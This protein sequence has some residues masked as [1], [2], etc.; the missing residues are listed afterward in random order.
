MLVKLNNKCSYNLQYMGK[1]RQI[2]TAESAFYSAGRRGCHPRYYFRLELTQP[3]QRCPGRVSRLVLTNIRATIAG[4]HNKGRPFSERPSQYTY[5]PPESLA[6]LAGGTAKISRIFQ[7][8]KSNRVV[9]AALFLRYLS[10]ACFY[11]RVRKNLRALSEKDAIANI[12]IIIGNQP[13]IKSK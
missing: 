13:V 9:P 1:I 5:L 8:K 4:F 6:P 3:Q 12:G 7:I 11:I 2:K 10:V